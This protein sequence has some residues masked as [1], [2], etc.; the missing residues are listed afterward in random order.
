MAVPTL[1]SRFQGFHD[2]IQYRVREILLVSTPYD[3]WILEQD[4]NLS[5]RLFSEYVQL[6][7]RFVPRITRVSTGRAALELLQRKPFDLVLCM[8]RLPDM[9]PLDF[10]ARAHDAVPGR[11]IAFLTHDALDNALHERL[12]DHSE[13]DRIFYWFRDTNVLTA[14]VKT[15]EDYRNAPSDTR[16]GVQVILLVEDSPRYYSLLLPLLYTEVLSQTRKLITDGVND[17]HRLQRMRARPK[18]LLA[19]TMRRA[20]ALVRQYGPNIIGVLTDV[21]FPAGGDLDER[22]GFVLAQEIRTQFPDVPVLL[23]SSAVENREAAQARGLGFV[24]KDSPE[25]AAGLRA[26]LLENCGF[27]DFIF[28]TP[29]G[30][31]A[32]R[33]ANL[34]ELRDRVVQVPDESLL[35]HAGRN[36]F[37]TW[38]RARTEFALAE[39]LRPMRVS[40]FA[41]AADLRREIVDALE[42][43]TV[44]TRDGEVR[45]FMPDR[46]RPEAN[47][48]KLGT[49]SLGG[50]A[51]G[52]AY[53]NALLARNLVADRYPGL[54]VV[55][56]NTFVLCSDIFDQFL[57]ANG[58]RHWAL[59]AADDDAISRRFSEAPLPDGVVRDLSALLAH[60]SYPLAVRS[61]SLLEDNQTLPF[62]GLYATFMLPNA[63][64]DPEVRLRQLC[65]AIKQVYASM[66]HRG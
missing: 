55:I 44:S 25:L 49:G 50:K 8:S 18:I 28:R 32:G 7:L 38:L 20:R 51:R 12:R 26:F 13:L 65:Q 17:F 40:D 14:I 34:Y 39:E 21:N 41:G 42:R 46:M 66:F 37:S 61:S 63:H 48:S 19:E 27:G 57:D 59:S 11:P 45:D 64:R 60:A 36:H 52:L 24:H 30:R 22:A 5:E 15:V 29:D 2:L 9:S 56:P 16:A 1:T 54:A 53:M 6:D 33:A 10:R 62:A 43:L 35:F 31:E 47:F 58:L 3:A 4:H 23:H